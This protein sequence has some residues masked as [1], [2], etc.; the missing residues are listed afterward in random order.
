MYVHYVKNLYEC[1]MFVQKLIFVW[2]TNATIADSVSVWSGDIFADV[3]TTVF[4]E[5]YVNGVR[6]Y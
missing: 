5:V 2:I 3:L 6:I 4:M 1:N